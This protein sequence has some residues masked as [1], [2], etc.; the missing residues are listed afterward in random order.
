[1]HVIVNGIGDAVNPDTSTHALA[2]CWRCRIYSLC[3]RSRL[4]CDSRR[5]L[6]DQCTRWH[7][8]YN[9]SLWRNAAV[10]VDQT[11][12]DE[13]LALTSGKVHQSVFNFGMFEALHLIGTRVRSGR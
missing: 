6:R 3:R 10:V 13:G 11:Y 5:L 2:V 1:M 9:G 12:S 8:E 7:D 4:R